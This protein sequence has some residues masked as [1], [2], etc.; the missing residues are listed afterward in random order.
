MDSRS[1][2]DLAAYFYNSAET[3]A[4]LRRVRARAIGSALARIPLRVRGL[5]AR[6]RRQLEALGPRAAHLG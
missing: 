2:P 1:A 3:H 4:R 6:A 5:L